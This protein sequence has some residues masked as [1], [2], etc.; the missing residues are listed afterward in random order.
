LSEQTDSPR[1]PSIVVTAAV[2]ERDGT[3]LVTRRP[4]GVHLAGLWEFPG[5]KCDHAESLPLCLM[6]EI[7]EELACD[8][9][10]GPEIFSISHAYPERV[11]TL[12]FFACTIKGDPK[13]LLGQELRWVARNELRTLE[14]PPADYE[15]IAKLS[16]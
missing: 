7:Q 12:H 3:Y 5:G 2:I 6:R 10:V 1:V 13:P 16:G 11:V 15:L 9:D 14:F 8:V 4:P